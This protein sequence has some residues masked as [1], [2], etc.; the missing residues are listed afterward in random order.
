[1]MSR[2]NA[3]KVQKDGEPEAEAL[4]L[5]DLCSEEQLPS[6]LPK[7]CLRSETVTA[8]LQPNNRPRQYGLS[9]I[10]YQS[11]GNCYACRYFH[12]DIELCG[13]LPTCRVSNP[14]RPMAVVVH[15]LPGLPEHAMN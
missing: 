14:S 2:P 8:I 6:S 10:C 4:P 1:M 15:S 9:V 3:K 11:N 5:F 7:A 12:G 13:S